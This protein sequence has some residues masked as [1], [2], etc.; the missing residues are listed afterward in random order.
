MRTFFTIL[1]GLALNYFYNTSSYNALIK[2]F[3]T[4]FVVSLKDL[5]TINATSID[6]T[7]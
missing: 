3:I 6:K 1:K 2:R 4:I 5:A 7:L